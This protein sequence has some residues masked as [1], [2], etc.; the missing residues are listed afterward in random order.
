MIEGWL[1]EDYLVL[2]QERA[3][4]FDRAYGVSETLPGYRPVGLRGWDD[5]I[6]EDDSG[7]QFTV[8]TIPLAREHLVPFN[9]ASRSVAL[10]PD[11]KFGGR[12][13]WHVKPIVFGGDPS[14][15]SN[16]AWITLDQYAELVRW[17][18]G[19]FREVRRGTPA[20]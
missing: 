7:A 12:V 5:F 6:V 17:W 16:V 10:E 1:G 9:G 14:A 11:P 4:E 3:G 13:K 19:K 20:A 2:F 8:P 18:N 15:E